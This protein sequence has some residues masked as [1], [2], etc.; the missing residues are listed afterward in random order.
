MTA[1]R[2]RQV[3]RRGEGERELRRVAVGGCSGFRSSGNCK[4]GFRERVL[5]FYFT[6]PRLKGVVFS[7]DFFN[8]NAPEGCRHGTHTNGTAYIRGTYSRVH[9]QTHTN[10]ERRVRRVGG[11]PF[12]GLVRTRL[13][14]RRAQIVGCGV[15]SRH[16]LSLGHA[17]V[18]RTS[19][20]AL[21]PS[22]ATFARRGLPTACSR[23]A[24]AETGW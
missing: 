20:D 24:R 23:C 16:R 22:P 1:R 10:L 13:S 19:R 5:F 17:H 8:I 21:P 11:A 15:D 12:K 18:K 7:R 3:R 4:F 6:A 14:D 9:K 2:T